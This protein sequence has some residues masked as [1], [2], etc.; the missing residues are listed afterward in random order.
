[1]IWQIELI[2]EHDIYE[3]SVNCRQI[4]YGVWRSDCWR[5][6]EKKQKLKRKCTG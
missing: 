6:E 1:M 2:R 5:I 4:D 3:R